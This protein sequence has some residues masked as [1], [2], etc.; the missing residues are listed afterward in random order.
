MRKSSTWDIMEAI[1]LLESTML[2]L[3][4]EWLNYSRMGE[5]KGK[6][7]KSLVCLLFIEPCIILI[8]E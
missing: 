7:V 5:I 4:C 8:V 6:M 1:F 3:L 2:L